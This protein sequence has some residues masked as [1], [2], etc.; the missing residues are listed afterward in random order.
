MNK[1]IVIS[2]G[3]S[4]IGKYVTERLANLNNKIIV[5]SKNKEKIAQVKKELNNSNIDFYQCDLTNDEEIKK[6]F[7]YINNKYGY[8]D[9]LINN[10]AYD[11]MSDIENYKYEDFSTI[12]NTN[13]LGKTFCTKYAIPMLRK[14]K[15]PSIINIA[16]RLGTRAMD[17]SSAYCCSAAAIIMLTKCSALEFEKYGIRVNC[18]SPS[19]VLTPLAK[20]SYTEEEIESTINKSTRKRLCEMKDIYELI[21]FLI[22]KKSDFINGENINISGGILLK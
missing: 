8:I 7:D 9:V 2:G 16:S 1:I 12:V 4:G 13:L 6:A 15:Y 11:V 3:T 22:S 5:L 18:I 20:K 19:M 10:A 21:E 17:L 14:S